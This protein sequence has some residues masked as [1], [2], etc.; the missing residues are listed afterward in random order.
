MEHKRTVR[1]K[2]LFSPCKDE[3][4]VFDPG[5]DMFMKDRANINRKGIN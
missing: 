5:L 4:V 1:L 3:E 2:Y